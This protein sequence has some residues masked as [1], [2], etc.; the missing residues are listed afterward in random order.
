MA[1]FQG[2]DLMGSRRHHQ[3]ACNLP[4]GRGAA[5]PTPSIWAWNSQLVKWGEQEVLYFS[6]ISMDLTD[7]LSSLSSRIID[8]EGGLPDPTES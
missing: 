6:F 8:G 2:G 5:G 4:G 3:P 1:S 7:P